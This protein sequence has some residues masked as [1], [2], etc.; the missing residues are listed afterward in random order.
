LPT[1]IQCTAVRKIIGQSRSLS[2]KV[3]DR[4]QGSRRQSNERAALIATAARVGPHSVLMKGKR[5][6]LRRLPATPNGHIQAS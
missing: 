2:T 6:P 5:A 4:I 1:E 3:S